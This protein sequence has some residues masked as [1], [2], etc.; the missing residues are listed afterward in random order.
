MSTVRVWGRPSRW[1]PGPRAPLSFLSGSHPTSP[2]GRGWEHLP[3]LCAL[4]GTRG[5]PGEHA[6]E[7]FDVPLLQDDTIKTRWGLALPGGPPR[8]P[9][10]Q[11][12][13]LDLPWRGFPYQALA[14]LPRTFFSNRMAPSCPPRILV[15]AEKLR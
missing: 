13:R 1:L 10:P 4:G 3:H 6:L 5:A 12:T 15:S 2:G 14:G 7:M 8:S 9:A 11:V